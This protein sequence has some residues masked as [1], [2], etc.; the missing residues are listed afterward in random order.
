M[1]RSGGEFFSSRW[2]VILA[3]LGMA[4]GTGNLWRFPRIA[5]QNGGAAFLIPWAIFLITWSLP[6]MIA[7]FGIGRAA[8]RGPVGAFT[9]L[10]GPRHAW[11]GGF[12]AVTTIMIM[13]YYAVVTGWALKYGL[14]A[15]TGQ[16]DG[17]D[18]GAYWTAYSTSVW[19]PLLFHA[20]AAVAGAAIV[21][22]GVASGIERA[23]R[24]L[25]PLLFVLLLV[26]VARAVT[27]P[28]AGRG[29]SF[30]FRPDLSALTSYR[31]WLEAL[32]QSAWSTGAGWGLIM[33]YGVYVRREEDVVVSAAA[34]GIGNNVASLLAGMAVLPTAFALL[35][36]GDALDVVASGNLGLTF[37]WV[38]QLF[39]K[40]P[41]GAFVLPVF[42]AALSCAALSSLIAM[43]ELATRVLMDGGMTRAAAVRLVAVAAVV[44]GVPSAVSLAVFE[45]QDWVWGLALMISGLFVAVAVIRYGPARFRRELIELK[46]GHVRL[47]RLYD[48]AIT[49]LVPVQ[50][51][52][53]FGW[54]MYQAVA[55][56][57]PEAWWNPIRMYS[58]GT[59]IVQWGVVLI[60][61]RIFNDRIAAASTRPAW[62]AGCG[63]LR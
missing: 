22:R 26:A 14:A 35:S 48:W 43:I 2:A 46:P 4:V 21:A 42:F 57:D 56:Y 10:V 41:G 11:M 32:T 50:F 28:G 58:L 40:V 39:A 17:V 33:A 34:I 49:Y 12:I 27:L 63:V 61:L 13:F 55:V 23:N 3:G 19:Q 44:C 59:C 36:V 9:M 15:L 30:L 8:R 1:T 31:T 29:L 47:G 37:I 60:V 52:V 45:N 16:L 18:A 53:M 7:E 62:G 51:V 6:I 54:W 5:A 24:V 20:L 25:I 38:P